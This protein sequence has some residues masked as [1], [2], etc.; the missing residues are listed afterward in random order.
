[1]EQFEQADDLR[2]ENPAG[3]SS[4]HRKLM[5]CGLGI[6][7]A[8]TAREVNHQSTRKS[9]RDKRRERK[10]NGKCHVRGGLGTWG[11]KWL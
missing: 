4:L 11:D 3:D 2:F 6:V 8:N 7:A 10:A 5:A 1:M 9:E